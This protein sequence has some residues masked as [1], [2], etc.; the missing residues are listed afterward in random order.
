VA[1]RIALGFE[2]ILWDKKLLLSPQVVSSTVN[3]RQIVLTLDQPLRDNGKLY[4]F[5]V[6]GEDGRFQNAEATGDGCQVV[7]TSPVDHPR[8]VRYAWKNNPLR[9]NVFGKNGLPMSPFQLA[10]DK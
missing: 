2:H 9:A 10:I 5:E 3:G 7:I 8:R 1:Q 6:A 4:E